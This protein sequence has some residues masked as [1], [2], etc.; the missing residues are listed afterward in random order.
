[1]NINILNTGKQWLKK[2]RLKFDQPR[3]PVITTLMCLL[4]VVWV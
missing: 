4:C 3:V 2:N 1:V